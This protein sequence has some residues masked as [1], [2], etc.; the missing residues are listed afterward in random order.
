MD[1]SKI[2]NEAIK[3]DLL[4]NLTGLKKVLDK[5]T[6]QKKLHLLESY[7]NKINKL[8]INLNDAFISTDE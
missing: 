2:R 4:E 5:W 7:K 8:I 3:T 6:S 1:Y